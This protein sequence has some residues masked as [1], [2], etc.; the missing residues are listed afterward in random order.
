MKNTRHKWRVQQVPAVMETCVVC[1]TERVC[2][3]YDHD[4]RG[5]ACIEDFLNLTHAE[6]AL[7][8]AQLEQPTDSIL[9]DSIP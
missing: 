4:L 8:E 3:A 6:D 2:V 7:A 9:G 1:E 5:H